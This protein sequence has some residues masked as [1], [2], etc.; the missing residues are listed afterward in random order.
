MIPFTDIVAST[1]RAYRAA[2]LAPGVPF[3]TDRD[4]RITKVPPELKGETF[5]QTA[6]SDADAESG[7][8]VTLNL[9]YPSTVFLVDDARA[10]A[11]PTWARETWKP[12]DLTIEGD[13][14]KAQALRIN[15]QETMEF[16]LD[17]EFDNERS[18]PRIGRD[19]Q[20]GFVAEEG[21]G[22]DHRAIELH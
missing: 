13:D 15:H 21:T 2:V 14:P 12:T 16:Q 5:L 10:E 6:C 7:I 11:L 19:G 4:Y 8:T 9:T 17:A 3:Y 1:G 22:G 20:G 18:P